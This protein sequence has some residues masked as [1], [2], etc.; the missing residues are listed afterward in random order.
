MHNLQQQCKS[1]CKSFKSYYACK[2]I[3]YEI[4]F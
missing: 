1:D 4:F 3:H 2:W